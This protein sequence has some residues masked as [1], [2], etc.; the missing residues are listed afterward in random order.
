MPKLMIFKEVIK[1]NSVPF[2]ALLDQEGHYINGKWVS[3]KPTEVP[4][5]GIILP[6]NNDDLKY[7]ESGVYTVKE[8]KL[9][10]VEPIKVDTKVKY[11]G[12]TYTIQSFKD[13]TEFTDVHI[14]LMRYRENTEGGGKV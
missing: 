3:G 1:Q 5:S 4:M 14:Y 8:K 12:D 6:L 2:T 13:L 11:K 10:V 7:I 9:Y